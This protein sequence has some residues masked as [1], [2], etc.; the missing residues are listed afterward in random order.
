MYTTHG[1]V[2]LPSPSP[3]VAKDSG[4][5]GGKAWTK[6]VAAAELLESR[7][8]LLLLCFEE[9]TCETPVIKLHE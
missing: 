4:S 3:A 2:Q 1:G 6:S 9:N 7:L 8:S 5:G